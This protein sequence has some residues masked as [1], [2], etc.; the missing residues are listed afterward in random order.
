MPEELLCSASIVALSF[1]FLLHT[2]LTSIHRMV[3]FA[4]VLN[5]QIPKSVSTASSAPHS[6]CERLLSATFHSLLVSDF[7]EVM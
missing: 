1:N 6:L 3:V 5:R 7:I 2:M 4:S